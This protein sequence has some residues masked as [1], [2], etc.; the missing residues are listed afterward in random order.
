MIYRAYIYS[1]YGSPLCP[2]NLPNGC[3]NTGRYDSSAP[4]GQGCLNPDPVQFADYNSMAQYARRQGETLL[5]VQSVTEINRLC[6]AGIAPLSAPAPSSIPG[7]NTY[8]P[9]I[10]TNTGAFQPPASCGG[11]TRVG[12]EQPSEPPQLV[13]DGTAAPATQIKRIIDL[14]RAFPNNAITY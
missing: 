1:P 5:E 3:Y 8:T 10:S 6:S 14:S 12:G 13:I 2:S 7:T 4:R 11:G 9:F